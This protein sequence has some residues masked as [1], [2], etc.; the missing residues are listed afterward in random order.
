M[1]KKPVFPVLIMW[2]SFCPMTGTFCQSVYGSFCP[3]SFCPT[4]GDY[5]PLSQL[6]PIRQ[7]LKTE[8]QKSKLKW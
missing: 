8:D 1:I 2:G 5:R 7:W 6:P 3:G 4:I